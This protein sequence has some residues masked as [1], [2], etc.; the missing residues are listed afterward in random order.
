MLTCERDAAIRPNTISHRTTLSPRLIAHR[1]LHHSELLAW[2]THQSGLLALLPSISRFL[3]KQD[4]RRDGRAAALGSSGQR[5]GSPMGAQWKQAQQIRFHTGR[6][7]GRRQSSRCDRKLSHAL[8]VDRC[9]RSFMLD[10]PRKQPQLRSG[11]ALGGYLLG[12]TM[13]EPATPIGCLP[14][15]NTNHKSHC[16]SVGSV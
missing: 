10:G 9:W 12:P 1:T 3:T 5:A 14:T 2:I 7:S 16:E 6:R 13:R 11:P 15:G 4:T 8:V